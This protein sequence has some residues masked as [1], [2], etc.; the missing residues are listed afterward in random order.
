MKI[1]IGQ[2]PDRKHIQALI[3]CKHPE[4]EALLDLFKTKLDEVKTA[5][6]LAEDPV[7]IHRLQGRAEALTDFLEA[8]EKS[9]EVL[10]RLGN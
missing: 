5:L 7:R 4:S 9:Q 10:A 6:I 8:V 3:R 1:F 2:K